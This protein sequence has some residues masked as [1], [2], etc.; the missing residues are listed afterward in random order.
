MTEGLAF[1]FRQLNKGG[2]ASKIRDR[3]KEELQQRYGAGLTDEEIRVKV[4]PL[5]L[6][7][8][9]YPDSSSNAVSLPHD[10]HPDSTF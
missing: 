4:T 5:R 3:V 9:I 2:G 8:N 6:R 10:L 7:L 1:A